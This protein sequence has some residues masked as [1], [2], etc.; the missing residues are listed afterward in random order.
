MIEIFVSN[1]PGAGLKYFVS[2]STFKRLFTVSIEFN[3][4]IERPWSENST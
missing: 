4:N 3:L 1:I 2:V